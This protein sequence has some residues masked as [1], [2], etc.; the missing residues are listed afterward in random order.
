MKLLW[1]KGAIKYI[2][3]K[4]TEKITMCR[5]EKIYMRGFALS[6]INSAANNTAVG[7]FELVYNLFR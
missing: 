1:E 5:E 3:N 2:K 4:L 6:T 7:W